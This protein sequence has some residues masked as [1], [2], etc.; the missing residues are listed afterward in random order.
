M[1]QCKNCKHWGNTPD[2]AE[3]KG[4]QV[5]GLMT[6]DKQQEMNLQ[7]LKSI[8][9]VEYGYDGWLETRPDFGCV[10]GEEKT[11]A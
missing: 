3:Y 2:R 4:T 6:R 7:E 5:C 10:L 8:V 9:F 1:I 11:D